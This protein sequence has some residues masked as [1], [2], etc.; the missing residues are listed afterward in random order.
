LKTEELTGAPALSYDLPKEAADRVYV[1]G[2]A[3]RSAVH[4]R[5][6]R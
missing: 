3:L 6:G 1:G 2:R 4:V 5:Q